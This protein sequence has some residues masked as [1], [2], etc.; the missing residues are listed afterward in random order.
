[1]LVIAVRPVHMTRIVDWMIVPCMIVIMLVLVSA[2]R[3]VNMTGAI[4]VR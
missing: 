3:P 1:M 4:K 2:I